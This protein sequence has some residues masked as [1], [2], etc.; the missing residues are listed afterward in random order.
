MNTTKARNNISRSNLFVD[1]KTK[2]EIYND[3]FQ[4][5]KRYNIP[6]AQLVIADIPY[7]LGNNAYGSSYMHFCSRLLKPEPK[8]TNTAKTLLEIDSDDDSTLHIDKQNKQVGD[9]V[10][11]ASEGGGNISLKA[12]GVK[13]RIQTANAVKS[14]EIGEIEISGDNAERIAEILK[15]ALE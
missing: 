4:N 1:P 15:R 3:N 13:K 5:Y 6:K 2:I 8:G 10:D 14:V 9:L 7:N 11:Y 12:K